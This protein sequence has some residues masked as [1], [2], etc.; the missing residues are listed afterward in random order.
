MNNERNLELAKAS[1]AG[2]L[3]SLYG[4][5]AAWLREGQLPPEDLREWLAERLELLAQAIAATSSSGE[6]ARDKEIGRALQVRRMTRGRPRSARADTLARMV[7]ENVL[8]EMLRKNVSAQAATKH[9]ADWF[10][11]QRTEADK[12]KSPQWKWVRQIALMDK[13]GEMT[14]ERAIYDAWLRYG[15]EVMAR[16][17]VTKTPKAK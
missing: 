17:G 11:K 7:A 2:A 10:D 5:A 12:Q 15:K 6:D 16:A 13:D 8:D 4:Q 3:R 1:D 14:S 9:V